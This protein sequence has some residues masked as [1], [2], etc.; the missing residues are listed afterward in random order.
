MLN[1]NKM[2]GQ[3]VRVII[4]N[5]ETLKGDRLMWTTVLSNGYYWKWRNTKSK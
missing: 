3:W 4:E 1:L 2:T 5:G